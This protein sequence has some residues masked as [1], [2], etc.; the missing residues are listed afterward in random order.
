MNRIGRISLGMVAVLALSGVATAKDSPPVTVA[1][2]KPD[3][4]VAAPV[5]AP[6]SETKP[7]KAAAKRNASATTEA[8]PAR[9][10]YAVPLFQQARPLK[11]FK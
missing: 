7:A 4:A 11:P 8:E 6:P 1:M 3:V 10:P 9:D 5:S 2:A